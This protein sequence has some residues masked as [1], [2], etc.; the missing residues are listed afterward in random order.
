M[1]TGVLIELWTQGEQ[2]EEPAEAVQKPKQPK[3]RR[4]AAEGAVAVK[5]KKNKAAAA[6]AAAAPPAVKA[7][8]RGKAAA[9]V[10]EDD[11]ASEGVPQTLLDNV[12]VSA[13]PF[14]VPF[15]PSF[16]SALRSV[17]AIALSAPRSLQTAQGLGIKF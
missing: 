2:K 15:H 1:K 17:F 16:G 12:G 11:S 10:E 13:G 7:K 4:D 9:E 6:A 14:E 3:A 8:P 5:P